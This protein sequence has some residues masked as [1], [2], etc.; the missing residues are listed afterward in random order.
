MRARAI[1]NQCWVVASNRIGHGA[2]PFSG[3]SA[4]VSPWGET[5]AAVPDNEEGLATAR[6][7]LAEVDEVRRRIPTFKDRFPGVRS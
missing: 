1:E 6:L 4:I 7:A 2:E 3:G 5:V